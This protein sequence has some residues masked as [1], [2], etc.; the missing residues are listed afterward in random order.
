ME[1]ETLEAKLRNQLSPIYGLVDMILLMEEKPEIKELLIK[2]AKQ[3]GLEEKYPVTDMFWGD[4]TGSLKDQF[5]VM[6]TM[7]PCQSRMMFAPIWWVAFR[8]PRSIMPIK[9]DY[10]PHTV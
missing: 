5:G 3:A 10:L 1:N 8:K 7:H 6:W 4:R 9:V 2:Q